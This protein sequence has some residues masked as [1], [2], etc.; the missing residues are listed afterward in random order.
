MPIE[1]FSINDAII[2]EHLKKELQQDTESPVM[3][4]SIQDFPNEKGYFMLWQL[5]VSTETQGQ[6]IVLYMIT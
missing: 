2:V 3:N 5:A 6:K 4:V 1:H